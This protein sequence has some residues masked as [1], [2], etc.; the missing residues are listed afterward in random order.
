MKPEEFEGPRFARAPHVR[1]LIAA[2][3]ITPALRLQAAGASEPRA[4]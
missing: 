2:G 1:S 4:A 3:R